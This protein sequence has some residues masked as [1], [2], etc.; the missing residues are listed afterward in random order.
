MTQ[1]LIPVFDIAILSL[2]YLIKYF[3]KS[4][5]LEEIPQGNIEPFLD[6]FEYL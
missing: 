1:I 6:R 2:L 5:S 4:L 3:Y